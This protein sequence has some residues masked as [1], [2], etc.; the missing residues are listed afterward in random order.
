MSKQN[1]VLSERGF[2][3]NDF[4]IENPIHTSLNQIKEEKRQLFW[5]LNG[6]D[7]VSAEIN[8]RT[9]SPE[10]KYVE[11]PEFKTQKD[12]MQ[13]RKMMKVPEINNEYVSV[14]QRIEDK[15][16][17]FI[18]RA[19]TAQTWRTWEVMMKERQAEVDELNDQS[20]GV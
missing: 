16:S 14:D 15:E 19:L 7:K 17:A 13:Y 8:K 6:L 20:F 2:N 9:S 5:E 3:K 18:R 4:Y 10:Y 12:L 11:N 1:N